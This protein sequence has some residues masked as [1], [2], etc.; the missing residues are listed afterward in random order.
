MRCKNPA[1]VVTIHDLT[2]QYFPQFHT[3]DNINCC[4][5]A[6]AFLKTHS[7]AFI[8]AISENTKKDYLKET[9][10]GDRNVR[11]IYEAAN[12]K[13]FKKIFH[14]YLF[15]IVLMIKMDLCIQFNPVFGRT[16]VMC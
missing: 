12:R 5:E 8:I 13:Q 2:H 6:L 4:N 16:I 15:Q 1:L 10:S 9:G 7:K 3:T 11:M 14:L